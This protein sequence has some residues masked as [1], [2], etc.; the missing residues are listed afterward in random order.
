MDKELIKC[1]LGGQTYE[2][3]VAVLRRLGFG[4]SL[5]P[6]EMSELYK[7]SAWIHKFK[8]TSDSPKEIKFKQR[9]GLLTVAE[10]KFLD[11]NICGAVQAIEQVADLLDCAI[12][13]GGFHHDL[14]HLADCDFQALKNLRKGF[15]HT[16]ALYL[17]REYLYR[18][19]H[20]DPKDEPTLARPSDFGKWARLIK[21]RDNYTCQ[22]C[23]TKQKPLHAHHILRWANE[24]SARFDLNNGKTLCKKCHRQEHGWKENPQRGSS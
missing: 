15:P 9:H 13:T 4:S 11:K 24:P 17:M 3:E 5:T 6:Y 1:I 16:E 22:K 8:E 19:E 23:Q 21:K 7:N 20:P 12:C 18:K 2:E 14:A 10:L